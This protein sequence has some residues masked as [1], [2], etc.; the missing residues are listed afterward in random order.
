M[1]DIIGD[2][3][4]HATPLK[5]LLR[6]MDYSEIDGVWQHPEREVIFL[7][8]FVDRG[9][10]QF[11]VIQIAKAMVEAGHALAVM[12]N[13]E[14]NAVS[15]A[16]STTDGLDFLRV[17]SEKNTRQHKEFLAQIDEGS[18]KHKEAIEWFKTLPIFLDLEG[19]R[20]IHACWHSAS[21]Q[22]L[23]DFADEKNVIR[24]DAW[25]ELNR[26]GS[27]A[28]DA[29]EIVLKGLEI[30]LPSG[31]DFDDKDGHTRNNIRTKWWELDAITYRDLAMVPSDVIERIP[32]TPIPEDLL[33]GYA[34]DKLL[35]VGHYWMSGEP[36]ALSPHIACLDYSIAAKAPS[37]RPDDRKLCAYRWGGETEIL[38]DNFISVKH[39]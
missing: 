13:H 6:K 37:N 39:A 24:S 34:G 36:T 23:A 28:Y 30:S 4:G 20:V 12:G 10:E 35:F 5:N 26:K 22:V 27:T 14:F 19:L 11:E 32:H 16:T 9:P 25:A 38:Q 8:D 21:L 2:I 1:Y 33:P 15:W 29:L 17:H 7:G 3:H 31:V 18:D